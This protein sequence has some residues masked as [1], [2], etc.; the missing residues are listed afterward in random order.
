MA[1]AQDWDEIRRAAQLF[2]L[3]GV[4]LLA[5]VVIFSDGFIAGRNTIVGYGGATALLTGLMI[6]GYVL[7]ERRRPTPYA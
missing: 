6:A 7:Q 3:N 5:T 2:V 1:F 4:A